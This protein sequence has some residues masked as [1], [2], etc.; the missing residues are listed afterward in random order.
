MSNL[1]CAADGKIAKEMDLI[2]KRRCRMIKASSHAL[3]GP[4]VAEKRV[5]H[6]HRGLERLYVFAETINDIIIRQKVHSNANHGVVS[7][8]SMG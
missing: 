1:E 4:Q 6:W 7:I 3:H 8:R 2:G 5:V